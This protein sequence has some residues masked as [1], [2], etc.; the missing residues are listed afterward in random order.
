M[1]KTRHREAL[2]LEFFLPPSKSAWLY[3]QGITQNAWHHGKYLLPWCTD[4]WQHWTAVKGEKYMIQQTVD[5]K[6]RNK[7]SQIVLHVK[8]TR[9]NLAM[10]RNHVYY[11][12]SRVI[13]RVH[14]SSKIQRLLDLWSEAINLKNKWKNFFFNIVVLMFHSPQFFLQELGV[15]VVHWKQCWHKNQKTEIA[16]Q[17]LTCLV[18]C[19]N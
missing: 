4:Y 16:M 10:E 5:V 3:L 15:L 9:P 7:H 19:V 13:Q 17:A 6:Q 1:N 2:R 11:T 18:H 14:N 8:T 12:V